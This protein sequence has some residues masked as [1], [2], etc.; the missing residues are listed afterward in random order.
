MSELTR[1]AVTTRSPAPL[2]DSTWSASEHAM[3]PAQI[4]GSRRE[5][6]LRRYGEELR[7]ATDT[8]EPA[9]LRESLQ[10]LQ[11]LLRLEP[12]WDSYG[13]K[14]IRLSTVSFALK[15]L[16][17]IAPDSLPAPAIVPTPLGGVQLEW[18]ERGVDIEI[19]VG[20]AYQA[21]FYF[22]D[23]DSGDEWEV[24]PSVQH[25][26]VSQALDRLAN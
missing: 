8:P 12:D 9:W 3:E 19:E 23:L 5:Y 25:E 11:R 15:T 26:G 6:T 7:V 1:F 4:Y 17:Q 13:A 16:D 10:Q 20:S 22:A 21:T 14:P 18:H 24:D 2:P